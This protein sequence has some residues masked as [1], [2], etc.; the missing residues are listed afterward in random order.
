MSGKNNSINLP[1]PTSLTNGGTGTDLTSSLSN[2]GIF[3]SG[4]TTASILA[5]TASANC[6]LLSGSSTTPSWST[7]TYPST[8]TFGQL[9]YSSANNVV[10]G[11]TSANS[12]HLVSNSSNTPIWS[13]TMSDGQVII[14]ST[15]ATPVAANLLAGTNIS[16]VNGDGTIT[17]NSMA[18]SGPN[19]VKI[20]T[21]TGSGSSPNLSFTGN[22]SSSY[23]AYRLVFRNLTSS[24]AANI[25]FL[26]FGTS[27][28]YVSSASYIYQLCEIAGQGTYNDYTGNG[29]SSEST[30]VYLFSGSELSTS[31]GVSGY[32]DLFVT[33]GVSA[34]ANGIS[35]TSFQSWNNGTG[36]DNTISTFQIGAANYTSV[37]LLLSLNNIS[38]TA[39]LYGLN[40]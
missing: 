33:S 26:E 40:T 18:G 21:Q 9:L 13:S 2:G 6:A 38:G 11:L 4:S 24:S 5:G 34:V 39:I 36:F 30:R 8:T 10:G 7:A 22:L 29:P 15:G 32:I 3:Y 37:R 19:W 23:V 20:A 12:A 17:I 35:H 14:G 16:I 1:F 28:G 27:G 31:P 25:L